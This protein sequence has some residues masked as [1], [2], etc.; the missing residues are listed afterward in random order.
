ML[1]FAIILF[2]KRAL[3]DRFIKNEKELTNPRRRSPCPTPR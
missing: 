2:K 3:F 1:K